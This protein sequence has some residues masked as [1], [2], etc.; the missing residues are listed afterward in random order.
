MNMIQTFYHIIVPI[1]I[2]IAIGALLH[3]K[4]RFDLGGF[5]KMILYYYVPAL[6][7]VKIYEA[8]LPFR[9]LLSVFGFLILQLVVMIFIGFLI[10][11]IMRYSPGM[12]ASFA[13][14][15]TLTNN[16][17]VGIPV[18]SMAFHQNP[19]AMSIQVIVV[20]FEL[21][22]TFTYGVLNAGKARAGLKKSLADFARMPVL[23]AIL[24]G[25]LFH[26]FNMTLPEPLLSPLEGIAD[27]MLPFA[28]A[29]IGAQIVSSKWHRDTARA[30]LL[31]SFTRLIL[32]PLCAYVIIQLLDLHGLT[33]QALF[34]ASAIPTSRNSAALALE[35][36]NEPGFA[37]QAV[38]VS[39]L[40]SSLTLTVVIDLAGVWFA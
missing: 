21:F 15:V 4:F 22:V 36:D 18:N 26:T 35:Y 24:A 32:A 25:T 40:L 12:S 3:R 5:S 16:G 27:G 8:R 2:P 11:R 34:I 6:A 37:A 28:L 20:V 14:S 23:Y 9:V 29:T 38:L 31:S 39:T 1:L 10:S 17:N 30:V 19:A 7:F 33:A 13:N